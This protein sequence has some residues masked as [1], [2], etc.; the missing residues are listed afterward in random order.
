VALQKIAEIYFL[1]R[2]VIKYDIQGKVFDVCCL[3]DVYFPRHF[4]NSTIRR[5]TPLAKNSG[6]SD[7]FAA[8]LAEF[9]T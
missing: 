5:T 7:G 1:R 9:C 2:A 8:I 4:L 3:C 6:D